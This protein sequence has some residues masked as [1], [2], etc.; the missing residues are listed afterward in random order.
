MNLK[1]TL[2]SSAAALAL[3]S[4]AAYAATTAGQ[5]G[6]AT[7]TRLA[8]DGTGDY[9]VFPVYAADDAGSWKT[10]IKVVN[11]NLTAAVVAKVVI[12]EAL[13]SAEKLD[14]PIYL[15]PGDVW[16]AE[17][18]KNG[19]NVEVYS[20]DDSIETQIS[21][22][23]SATTSWGNSAAFLT[24]MF[25]P[26]P[27]QDSEY[28][29]VE[30]FGLAQADG[31]YIDSGFDEGEKL[32]KDKIRYSFLSK[33]HGKGADANTSVGSWTG[34]DK[35]S[36]AGLETVFASNTAGK[37]AAM[38]PATAIEGVTGT[39]EVGAV[40]IG[41]ETN[42]GTATSLSEAQILT[43]IVAIETVLEKNRIFILHDANADMTDAASTQLILTQPMKLHRWQNFGSSLGAL[44]THY[45]YSDFNED[46]AT[47]L[48]DSTVIPYEHYF[49]YTSVARNQEEL[50]PDAPSG[51]EVSGG[52]ILDTTNKCRPESCWINVTNLTAYPK[53]FVT[54]GIT[55]N[56]TS[57]S[58]DFLLPTIPVVMTG[59][60]VDGTAATNMFYPAYK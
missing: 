25:A 58:R 20:A 38:L 17:I 42:F 54:L 59:K 44:N 41:A 24:P 52:D 51:N 18:R 23:A 39:D 9:L 33:V 36:L 35:N 12:R 27:Y 31:K 48:V 45:I 40:T 13:S 19:D 32:S 30:V 7:D 57:V 16:E 11:T 10:N 29:Y 26:K 37:I 34:V 47:P 43:T 8:L 22:T 55:T 50:T 3:I 4:G 5:S 49:T 2:L 6:I 46:D 53:G 1:R 28:G 14:F 60:V 21:S 56:G 15:S